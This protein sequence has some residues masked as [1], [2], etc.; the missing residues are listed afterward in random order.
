[1]AIEVLRLGGDPLEVELL[2]EVG[3]ALHRVR[4]FGV[5]LLRTPQTP[6]Q[7]RDD[8]FFWGSFAMV[9]W[10][11]RIP[12]GRLTFQGRT[13]QIPVNFEDGSAIHGQGVETPW[14]VAGP[15]S[16][17]LAGREPF[18][19]PYTASQDVAVEGA[20][21]TLTV[22]VRNDGS[23]AM[24]AGLG[25]HPWFSAAGGLRVRV[26]ARSS[27][28]HEGHL[29][30]GEPRPIPEGDHDP[31]ALARF[32]WGA[33]ELYTDLDEHLVELSWPEH[34]LDATL[35]FSDAA[36]HVLVYAFQEGNTVAVEP[37]THASDGY[38]RLA[39][40]ERG[41]IGVLDPGQTLAVTYHLEVRRAR[42]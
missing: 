20:R 38:G 37:Q 6:E 26:P 12:G 29:A 27:Y 14:E 41:A 42:G 2:P 34:G 16:L 22:A 33:H 21:L 3:G 9:P 10:C 32:P 1:M 36:D 28:R 19:W 23:E 18:P 13:Y 8:P 31:R 40:G 11:N 35:T 5:D 30:V 25:I 39:R 17:R 4:A 24:P 7:H 15:G